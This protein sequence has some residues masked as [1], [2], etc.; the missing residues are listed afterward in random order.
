MI[1][2]F[3]HIFGVPGG[4]GLEGARVSEFFYYESKSKIYI[5]M[6]FFWGGGGGWGL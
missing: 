6:F 4:G 3:I 5:K 2:S 1:Y